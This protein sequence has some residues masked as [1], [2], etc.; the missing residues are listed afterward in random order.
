MTD[1][2]PTG[3]AAQCC[4]W[5]ATNAYRAE[6][7]DPRS[8][9]VREALTRKCDQCHAPAGELCVKRGGFRSDLKARLIHI[10]RMHKP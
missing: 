4:A 10:G 8:E 7:L 2:T 6:L 1:T 3:F 5:A 9:I